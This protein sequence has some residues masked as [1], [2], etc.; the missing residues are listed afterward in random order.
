MST[1]IPRLIN[2]QINANWHMRCKTAQNIAIFCVML[3]NRIHIAFHNDT[4]INSVMFLEKN[5]TTRHNI[6]LFELLSLQAF[7]VS[8]IWQENSPR[9]YTTEYSKKTGFIKISREPWQNAAKNIYIALMLQVFI[10]NLWVRLCRRRP[11]TRA[12]SYRNFA[13]AINKIFQRVRNSVAT[14]QKCER[15]AG[16]SRNV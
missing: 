11:N 1:S 16:L 15:F 6:R 8:I 14:S 13:S 9:L 4:K 5:Y 7:R 2:H 12:K 10:W 3:C